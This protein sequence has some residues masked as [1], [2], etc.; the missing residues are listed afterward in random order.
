MSVKKRRHVLGVNRNGCYKRVKTKYKRIGEYAEA[1]IKNIYHKHKGAYGRIRVT[2]VV[3]DA[4]I[5]ID[6][7][8]V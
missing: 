7:K 8:K 4:G 3:R 1:E 5:T 2:Q 6:R